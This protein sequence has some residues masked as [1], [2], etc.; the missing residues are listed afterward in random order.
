[1]SPGRTGDFHILEWTMSQDRAWEGNVKARMYERVRERGYDSLTA[2][3]DASP[4]ASLGKQRKKLNRD[5]GA[6]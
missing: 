6:Q 4:T 5:P 3:T 1:M 2:F